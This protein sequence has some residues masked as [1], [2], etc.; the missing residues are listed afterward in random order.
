[1]KKSSL[2][3]LV[4]LF[5][6][7]CQLEGGKPAEMPASAPAPADLK[8]CAVDADCILMD[9]S[10]HGCCE[11]DAVSRKDSTRYLE[12]KQA[13]CVGEMGYVCGCCLFPARAAC[14]AG[15]C[16]YKVLEEKCSR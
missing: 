14:E 1:M 15:L 12:H 13:T 8:Q 3:L 4:A 9:I 16:N 11:R 2:L 7:G 6:S 5:M 10:C